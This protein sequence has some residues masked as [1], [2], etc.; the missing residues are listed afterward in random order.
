[1]LGMGVSDG[2]YMWRSRGI[3][4]GVF[5]RSLMLSAKNAVEYGQS[6]VLNGALLSAILPLSAVRPLA[7]R[8]ARISYKAAGI[9]MLDLC[10]I[11]HQMIIATNPRS[12][13]ISPDIIHKYC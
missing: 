3:D 10:G 6:D 9:R 7:D 13:L 5:S 11:L 4:A 8:R 2:V 12:S 1:M